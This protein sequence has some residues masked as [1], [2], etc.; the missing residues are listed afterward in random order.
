M[1]I[2]WPSQSTIMAIVFFIYL[3]LAMPQ[4]A[5]IRLRVTDSSEVEVRELVIYSRN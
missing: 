3:G 4:N 5:G 2:Q 1:D